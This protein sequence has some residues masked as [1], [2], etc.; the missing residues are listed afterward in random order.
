MLFPRKVRGP[1]DAR[2]TRKEVL[3]KWALMNESPSETIVP[4]PTELRYGVSCLTAI[5]KFDPVCSTR[6]RSYPSA[7]K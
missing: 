4:V 6:D 2:D 5:P 1:I 7:R 3:E